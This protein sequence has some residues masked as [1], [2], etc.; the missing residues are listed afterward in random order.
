MSDHDEIPVKM[1]G[2][3]GQRQEFSRHDEAGDWE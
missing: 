1:R 2:V 3:E